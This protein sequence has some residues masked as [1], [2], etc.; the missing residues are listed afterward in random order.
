MDTTSFYC[1]A[2]N[3]LPV[4]P[5]L[6][7]KVCSRFSLS[8]IISAPTG[9]KYDQNS[10]TACAYHKTCLLFIWY[11]RP[12]G[13]CP[14]VLL[15]IGHPAISPPP[16]GLGQA[17]QI[18]CRALCRRGA[19][20]R[21]N[22]RCTV[23]D[24]C[25]TGSCCWKIK[26]QG[27]IAMYYNDPNRTNCGNIPG[28][29]P[30]DE[31]AFETCRCPGAG[32]NT[33]RDC[34]CCCNR[35][36]TGPQGPMGPRGCP[37]PQ[38]PMGY[39]GPQG[40]I[41]PAGPIGPQGF[42]GIPGP[43]GPTGPTG[44]TGTNGMNGIMGPT[45]PT[46][47]NGPAGATGATGPTGA[48]GVAGPTG[49]TGAT[50]VTGPTGATGP[51]GDTNSACCGCTEQ[52]R[53][54]L[55]QI[56]T[57]YPNNNIFVTLRSGDAV[58]GRP[59]ALIPGPNG[60]IGLFEVATTQNL[61]QFLSNCSIDTIQINNATYND[62]IV[63]LPEPVPAPTDCCSDCESTIRSRLPVGTSNVSI[64]T[65]TQTPSTG[66]VIRNEFGMIVLANEAAATITFIS[67]CSIDLFFI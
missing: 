52:I 41:G 48:N 35:G 8:C 56:V 39:P 15:Q 53:N 58:V 10:R 51:A 6:I 11:S 60:R 61:S 28:N 66:T 13:G 33:P 1:V 46:G 18:A 4:A 50:G 24:T 14:L 19:D 3:R 9:R 37:G 49:P 2:F 25:N 44:A 54:I 12:P 65:S 45:G 30:P 29:Y 57:L 23:H 17:I 31:S 64:I 43:T 47:A 20:H 5:R 40:P 27:A 21:R 22:A 63:Y 34:N 67:S 16:I 42:P 7:Y 62:T 55:Q 38:G 36:P 32:G 26:K 59:G